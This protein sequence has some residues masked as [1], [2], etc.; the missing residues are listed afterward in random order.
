[1]RGVILCCAV[2]LGLAGC[3]P[4]P[5]MTPKPSGPPPATDVSRAS[6]R[7]FVQVIDRIEPVAEQVCRARTRGQRCDFK[8]VVDDRPN[9]PP[10]AFQTEDKYGRPVIGFTLALIKRARNADEIAFV[11]GH[12]AAHHIRGHLRQTS[13]NAAIGA[14]VLGGL[15]TAGGGDASAVQQAQKVGSI[16][17]QRRYSKVFELEA[18]AL[19]TII[20]K[21]AGFDPVRG[22]EFFNRI[23]DPGDRFLGSHPPNAKRIEVVRRTAAQM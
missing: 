11:F 13:K 6:A 20:T 10:N 18:D 1:M 2:V 5:P 16:L 17:G 22:A 7:S 3:T 15:V 9:V 23:P 19:G 8:V 12:E 14:L 4:P 21:Q